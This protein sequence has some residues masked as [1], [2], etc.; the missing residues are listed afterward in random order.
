MLRGLSSAYRGSNFTLLLLVMSFSGLI[1]GA[2]KGSIL[3]DRASQSK[4][5]L[6]P[7]HCHMEKD[8]GS[9]GCQLR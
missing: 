6:A 9:D 4:S 2:D 7:P 3:H 5:K 1:P 8:T